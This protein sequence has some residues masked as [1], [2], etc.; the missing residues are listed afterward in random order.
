MVVVA[1]C[2]VV[3]PVTVKRLIVVVAKVEVPLTVRLAL[4]QLSPTTVSLL[5]GVE[6]PR[7][8]FPLISTTFKIDP[9]ASA[10]CISAEVCEDVA[11]TRSVG[12]V[13]LLDATCKSAAGVFVPR[14][15][16]LLAKN[17]TDCGVTVASAAW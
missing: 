14:P 9:V 15:I 7:P 8:R 3:A 1:A 11:W 2:K 12:K 4:S 13:V 16:L 6:V 5:A 10:N 17:K